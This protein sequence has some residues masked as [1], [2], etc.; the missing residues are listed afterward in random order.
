MPDIT[1]Y[2]EFSVD[3]VIHIVDDDVEQTKIFSLLLGESFG[4]TKAWNSAT[5]WMGTYTPTHPTVLIVDFFFPGERV[6]GEDVLDWI[7]A[8]HHPII[9]LIVSGD[10]DVERCRDWMRKG[11]IY[12]IQK[13][14]TRSAFVKLAPVLSQAK[15]A[16]ISK[17]NDYLLDKKLRA[18]LALCTQREREIVFKRLQGVSPKSIADYFGCKYRTVVKHFSNAMCNLVDRGSSEQIMHDSDELQPLEHIQD[19][20]RLYRLLL[21]EF[22]HL[23][24]RWHVD[25]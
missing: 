4:K 1:H 15:D 17:Y 25:W 3:T 6:S 9:P 19:K 24:D 18:R 8:N 23:E 14:I 12:V 10:V 11:A 22:G 20:V 7:A 16:S 21:E 2:P 13:P 5:S